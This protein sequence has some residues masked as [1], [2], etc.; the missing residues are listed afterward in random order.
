[1][2]EN[3]RFVGITGVASKE[4]LGGDAP[5][6]HKLMLVIL[7]QYCQSDQEADEESPY[8]TWRHPLEPDFSTLV[9][10]DCD[11]VHT[12]SIHNQLAAHALK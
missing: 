9:L 7:C 11:Y 5:I 4:Q 3:L 2:H 8:L 1:M 6:D 10:P 12:L